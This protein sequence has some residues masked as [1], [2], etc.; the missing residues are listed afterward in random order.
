[1]PEV[2]SQLVS[3]GM[4]PVGSSAKDFGATIEKNIQEWKQIAHDSK[5]KFEG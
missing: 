1:M 5:F 4:E 2:K 3:M